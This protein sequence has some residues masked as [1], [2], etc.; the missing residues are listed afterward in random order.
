[1]AEPVRTLP[2]PETRG[3]EEPD[4]DAMTPGEPLPDG[5]PAPAQRIP[6]RRQVA[7]WCGDPRCGGD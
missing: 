2:E 5:E 3:G 1:M 6:G 7:D 4:W